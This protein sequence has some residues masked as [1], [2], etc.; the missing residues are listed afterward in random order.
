MEPLWTNTSAPILLVIANF[1][2]PVACCLHG[3][4]AAVRECSEDSGWF[5]SLGRRRLWDCTT[6]PEHRAKTAGR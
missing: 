4:W 3:F 6:L 1:S 2:F 5:L